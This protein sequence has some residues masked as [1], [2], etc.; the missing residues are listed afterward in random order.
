[1]SSHDERIH[2]GFER[3]AG[4]IERMIREEDKDV[5]AIKLA[6]I[7]DNLTQVHHMPNPDSIA[8]FLNK[9]CP[10]F[11]YYGNKYFSGTEFYD[12]FLERYFDQLRRLYQYLEF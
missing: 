5:W 2:D 11:V 8:I 9:K 12:L 6:D 3:W 1:M 4:M 10:V 7:S